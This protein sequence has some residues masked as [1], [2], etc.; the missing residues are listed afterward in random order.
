MDF[1]FEPGNY[2]LAGREQLEGKT[3]LRIEYYPT[4]L[5]HD[6]DDNERERQQRARQSERAKQTEQRIERQMNKTA[7]VTIWV[8]PSEHQI[9]KYTFDN[10]WMDFL[11]GKWLVRVDDIQASMT[12]GQPFPDVWLP[13][14]MNIHAG[15]TLAAG[16]LEAAYERRFSSYKLAETKTLIRIPKRDDEPEIFFPEPDQQ[17]AAAPPPAE[18]VTEIRV[19]GNAYLR[20]SEVIRLA[21]V[22]VGQ[23][24]GPDG[25]RQIEQRL[26]KSGYFDTVEIRKRYRSLDAASDVALVLLVHER[27]G[28]TSELAGDGP[29]TNPWKRLKSRLMF[30]PIVDYSRRL[31][32]D[33]R[34]HA[35]ALSVCSAPA[36]AC[37]C[38]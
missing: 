14:E 25:V 6:G 2:Y 7:L 16:S 12:M 36:S 30:L 38:R 28:Q 1:K 35:S 34:R 26:E 8:D 4:R 23:P 3:V 17:P 20:D 22:A 37:P 21:G 5:F 33:L 10:I 13:R 24:L 31:R 11:P 32:P 15:V 29:S 9:V 19:H 27:A 18:V